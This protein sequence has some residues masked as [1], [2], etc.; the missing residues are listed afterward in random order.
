MGRVNEEAPA[1]QFGEMSVPSNRVIKEICPKLL[2][3]ILKNIFRGSVKTQAGSLIQHF[4]TIIEN[5]EKT[6]DDGTHLV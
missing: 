3:P 2:R 1:Q 4:R 6:T 5:A